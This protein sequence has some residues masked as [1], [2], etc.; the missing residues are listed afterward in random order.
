MQWRRF[1]RLAPRSPP[2]W[3]Q[4]GWPRQ[5]AG[6]VAEAELLAPL[7]ELLM[8][9]MP[10][11]EMFRSF[12]SPAGW[13]GNYL[14]PDLT[15]YG[16]FKKKNAAMFVEYDGYYRHATKEGMERDLLKNAALL[17]FA[18][19]GSFVVRIIHKGRTKLDGHVLW[20]CVNSWRKGDHLSATGALKATLEVA[21]RRLEA[22]LHPNAHRSLSAHLKKE[23]PLLI[24][25]AALEFREATVVLGGGNTTEEISSFLSAEGFRPP[26]IHR[27]QKRAL[28]SGVSITKSLQPLFQFLVRLEL[29]KTQ[30]AKVLARYPQILGLSVEQNLK[31][32]VRWF[33]DLGLTNRQ[34]AKVVATGPQV[35][36]LSIDQN[37]KPTTQWLLELGLTEDQLAI[38]LARYPA[39]L[40]KSI[41]QNLKPTMQ[42]VFDLGLTKGQLAK[43]VARYP[44]ILG[45]SVEQNLKPTVRWF[46]D[47]GLTNSQVAKVVATGPQVLGLSIDQN[48]KPTT[49]W[50]L[51]LGLTEDQLAIV[52]ARYPTILWK[53]I[54]QNLKPTMQWV[55]DLGLTKGQLAKVVA[56]YPQILGL[57]VEQNLKPT[58]RWFLDLGLTNSQVAKVVATGPQVLGLSIDQNLKPTVQ[59]FIS[60]G[61]TKTQVVHALA[62]V[63]QIL[64][65]S[66]DKS[67]ACKIKLLQSFLTTKDVVDLI[68]KWPLI[69]LYRQQRLEER[70]N[71]LARQDSLGK[72]AYAMTLTDAVFHRRFVAQK[73]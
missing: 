57:S 5:R 41:Q 24:S 49:Q 59:W 29:S 13:R 18:P 60:L 23:Q 48:L 51:E 8:P 45:L 6:S 19:A 53:S 70:L 21:A 36:G 15:A 54:Q 73:N 62:T 20:V 28:S 64:G 38:V 31:P 4:Q 67:L 55:F 61:L 16:L 42:W 66:V 71:V 37:L 27:M 10:I 32:T 40:S 3:W 43:V 1:S 68:A 30:I 63:P 14:E 52:V 46:L 65:S 50:L 9:G 17:E 35:L 56:R 2:L 25:Q 7:G 11:G 12:K 72:L 69:V 26:D 33:L 58:V 44:Q 22:S 34:V 39:I 47:L